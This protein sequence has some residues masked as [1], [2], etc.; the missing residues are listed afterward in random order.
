MIQTL[1]RF[2]KC[3]PW[4]MGGKY[5]YR[6]EHCGRRSC[7]MESSPHLGCKRRHQ[8]TPRLADN[9]SLWGACFPALLYGRPACFRGV[10]QVCHVRGARTYHMRYA[11]SFDTGLSLTLVSCLNGGYTT[12]TNALKRE[13]PWRSVRASV[14]QS[15]G[16][17]SE[18]EKRQPQS[19]KHFVVFL[20]CVFFIFGGS[21]LGWCY[22]GARQD[23][24]I[25]SIASQS[26]PCCVPSPKYTE[27]QECRGSF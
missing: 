18:R 3:A 14:R 19:E 10:F 24:F 16:R 7:Q 4:S 9:G 13:G 5:I 6:S 1:L 21:V 27:C 25:L 8:M 23:D 2:Y 26:S 17:R 12:F 11:C 15:L 22:G 20:C